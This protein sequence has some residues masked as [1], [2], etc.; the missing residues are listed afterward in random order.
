MK[1]GILIALLVAIL[2]S[3]SGCIIDVEFEAGHPGER[4][5]IYKGI[6]KNNSD[7]TLR[8]QVVDMA[9]NRVIATMKLSPGEKSVMGLREKNYRF[10]AV[11]AYSGDSF[12]AGSMHING[13]RGDAYW[14]GQSWDW[15][16]V[17]ENR[18]LHLHP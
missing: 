2:I 14:S 12:R 5:A 6:I 3:I 7:Y 13:I 8:V 17:F 11:K 18:R 15:F 9:E 10:I 1:K 4:G 16:A